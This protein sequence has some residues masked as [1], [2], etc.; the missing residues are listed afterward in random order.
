MRIRNLQYLITATECG[1]LNKAAEMLYLSQP[2]LSFAIHSLEKEVGY[3]IFH[4]T[5]K[6][7]HLTEKGQD[8]VVLAKGILDNYEKMQN[9]GD[10]VKSI[11]YH[12]AANSAAILMEPF[13]KLCMEYQSYSRFQF[14]LSN[15]Q[16]DSILE[17]VY[18]GKYELG[19][20][21]YSIGQTAEIN[22]TINKYQLTSK[23]LKTL[24]CNINLRKNHPAL[25]GGFQIEKLWDYPFVDY[26][27]RGF[28]SYHEIASANIIN[29]SRLFLVDERELRCRLVSET[30]A[31]SI[32]LPL[33]QKERSRF[34]WISIPYSELQLN[35]AYVCKK[36]QPFDSVSSNYLELLN[37]E[38]I[39]LK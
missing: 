8:F 2:N 4:R 30:N 19:I 25:E 20:F 7:I 6:G 29:P 37:Q 12:L 21:V 24:T 34:N 31:F 32:G 13:Y 16:T 10:S 18:H 15:Q 5:S 35:L 9:L 26:S 3:P 38:L 27:G 36:N 33:S 28:S 22:D 17:D 1:S 23:H 39:Q 11:H 14:T